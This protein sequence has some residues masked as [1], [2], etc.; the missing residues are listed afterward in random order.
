MA[1]KNGDQV[2]QR[3]KFKLQAGDTLTNDD[4]I[5]LAFAPIMGGQWTQTERIKEA[6]TLSHSITN[7]EDKANIQSILFAFA[8]KFLSSSDLESVKEAILMTQLGQMIYDDGKEDGR[9]EGRQLGKIEMV[10]MLLDVLSDDLLA[11]ISGL[12]LAELAN[13]RAEKQ[14]RINA[15]I[16]SGNR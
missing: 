12:S 5:G 6:I 10:I 15:G 11:E 9:Q 16:L 3:L 14:E 2:L 13:L 4:L 8:S 1:N 7:S